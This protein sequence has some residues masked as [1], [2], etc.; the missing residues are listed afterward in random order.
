[1][2][3]TQSLISFVILIIII[4]IVAGWAG[5][6]PTARPSSRPNSMSDAH[7]RASYLLQ[8]TLPSSSSD[9]HK[10]KHTSKT[11][12]LFFSCGAQTQINTRSYA[13]G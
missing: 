12:L 9:E 10:H 7:V 2:V 6:W 4:F 1:M 11:F 8:H 13:K 3:E 5:W